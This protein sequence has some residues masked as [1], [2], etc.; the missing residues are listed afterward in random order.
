MIPDERSDIV[1]QTIAEPHRTA[2]HRVSP[3]E[4]DN[5]RSDDIKHSI[6]EMVTVDKHASD[7]II[8]QDG[9][10]PYQKAEAEQA[11][12]VEPIFPNSLDDVQSKI[13]SNNDT[14][15]LLEKLQK[16]HEVRLQRFVAGLSPNNDVR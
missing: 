2:I 13:G 12:K 9:N 3:V 14:E 15:E 1:Q 6:D 16:I 8:E 5:I 4:M 11:E 10:D 7:V